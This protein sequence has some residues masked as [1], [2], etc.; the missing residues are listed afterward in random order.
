MLVSCRVFQDRAGVQTGLMCERTGPDIGGL[1]L[2]H[3]VQNFIELTA[4]F[5]QA[6][7][8]FNTDASLKPIR[9]LRL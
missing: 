5:Q 1:A 2:W 8:R 9:Q 4:E 6:F 3:T 7:E